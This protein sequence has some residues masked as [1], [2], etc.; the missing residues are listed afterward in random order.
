MKQIEI[1]LIK[2]KERIRARSTTNNQAG[3]LAQSNLNASN[4]QITPT[5]PVIPN[6]LIYEYYKEHL[7]RKKLY[8]DRLTYDKSCV[9]NF[10]PWATDNPPCLQELEN[11]KK[12][13]CNLRIKNDLKLTFI[14]N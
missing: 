12:Q 9:Y 5:Q 7:N 8:Q 3:E 2:H 6:S 14:L 11:F 13:D 1:E 10:P 4:T